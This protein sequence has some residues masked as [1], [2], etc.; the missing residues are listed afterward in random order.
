M[1]SLIFYLGFPSGL[2]MQETWIQSLGQVSQMWDLDFNAPSRNSLWCPNAG[3]VTTPATVYPFT[4]ENWP[5]QLPQVCTILTLPTCKRKATW[6]WKQK[7]SWL[8]GDCWHKSNVQ[9]TLPSQTWWPGVS[10]S[11]LVFH[12]LFIILTSCPPV[13][14]YSPCS[15]LLFLSYGFSPSALC[16][17]RWHCSLQGEGLASY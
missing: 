1:W 17:C 10:F 4:K 16:F 12:F 5:C 11:F 3:M 2:V 6:S 14:I 7:Y 9:G 13:V 15:L 8:F